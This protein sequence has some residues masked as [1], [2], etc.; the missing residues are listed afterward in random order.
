MEIA[1]MCVYLFSFARLN[2]KGLASTKSLRYYVSVAPPTTLAYLMERWG[3]R[4]DL[5]KDIPRDFECLA[6]YQEEEFWEKEV[7]LWPMDILADHE[8]STRIQEA[9]WLVNFFAVDET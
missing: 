9:E 5:P 3:R 7:R 8:Y 6:W 1:Q 2:E 4:V